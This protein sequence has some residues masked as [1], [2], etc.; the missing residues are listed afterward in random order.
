MR[1]SSGASSGGNV[2]PRATIGPGPPSTTDQESPPPTSWASDQCSAYRSE[3][4][5]ELPSV[6][7][8]VP[9]TMV[10]IPQSGW[11]VTTGTT[12]DQVGKAMGSMGSPGDALG[13]AGADVTSDGATDGI[14][15][16]SGASVSHGFTMA[17][18]SATTTTPIP[19]T[20]GSN[21]R[22]RG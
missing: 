14:A 9:T 12:S 19:M 8:V 10:R 22:R 6:A 5:T 17:R 4:A 3:I 16:T 21:R 2:M 7:G 15:A 20:S 13:S 1:T 18:T 11:R